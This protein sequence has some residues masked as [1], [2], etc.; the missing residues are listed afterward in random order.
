MK[1]QQSGMTLIELVIVIIVLGIIAAVAAPKFADIS[2]NAS[3]SAIA[4]SKGA[5]SS[6]YVIAIGEQMGTPTHA[7]LT[8]RINGL[9]CTTAITQCDTTADNDKDT[10]TDLSITL[11]TD[12]A[13]TTPVSA[14]GNLVKGYG[15]SVNGA[16]M[17][18]QTT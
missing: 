5:F 17:V 9:D 7:Q 6:A 12:A 15:F 4:G 10:N 13:C 18:C 1:K 16:T 3:T 14:G 8:L 2:G 11:Y